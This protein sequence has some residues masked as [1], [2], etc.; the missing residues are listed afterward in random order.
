MPGGSAKLTSGLLVVRRINW[1]SN[2]PTGQPVATRVPAVGWSH[3]DILKHY[4]GIEGEAWPDGEDV[5][6]LG[7]ERG[8]ASLDRFDLVIKY[9]SKVRDKYLCDLV[10]CHEALTGEVQ[11]LNIPSGFNFCGFDY[12]YY[13]SEDNH[14][15]SLYNEIIYGRHQGLRAYAKHLN[16]SLLF[17]T[18]EMVNRVDL[19]RK[20]LIKD[21]ADLE[22]SEGGEVFT[23]IA[24]H[25]PPANL[26]R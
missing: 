21:G 6:H 7:L 23:A 11:F 13:V 8:L 3:E 9:Y 16:D 18:I 5:K 10:H 15:S 22:T 20:A 14:Y 17:P 1:F 24:I 26:P 2:P 4:R 12:G 19:T 25:A